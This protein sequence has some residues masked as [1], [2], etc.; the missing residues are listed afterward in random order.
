MVK[1]VSLYLKP[2][3]RY[4]A[5]FELRGNIVYLHNRIGSELDVMFRYSQ[6]IKTI[7]KH[8]ST[9]NLSTVM[10]GFGGEQET[11]ALIR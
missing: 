9:R 11:T 4:K 7:K 1:T 6:Q 3:D 10:R 2:L 5:E 8:V